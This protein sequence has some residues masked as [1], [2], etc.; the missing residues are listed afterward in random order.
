[1]KYDEILFSQNLGKSQKSRVAC[2]LNE[3]E[4]VDGDMHKNTKNRWKIIV[5]DYFDLKIQ[6]EVNSKLAVSHYKL[7]QMG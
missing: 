2:P 3:K 6:F 4:N 7:C 5:W 1:M